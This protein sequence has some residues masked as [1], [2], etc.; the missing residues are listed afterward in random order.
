V[1]LTAFQRRAILGG[2]LVATVAAALVPEEEDASPPPRAREGRPVRE[3][4]GTRSAVSDQ[5]LPQLKLDRLAQLSPRE[6]V[7]DAFEERSWGP[8][9]PKPAPPPPPVAP[10][11]PFK[12]MGKI[13]DGGDIVVFLVKQDSNYTVRSGDKIDSNYQVEEIKPGVMTFNYLPLGQK[14]TLAIG[15]AN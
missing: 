6:A 13:M 3:T 14:Q 15:A 4:S 8:P 7:R 9:P 5:T 12:Y 2:V 10:P 11:L 1:K